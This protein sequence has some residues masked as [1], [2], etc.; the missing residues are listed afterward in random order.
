MH[1]RN[2]YIARFRSDIKTQTLP[3]IWGVHEGP[4]EEYQLLDEN[5]QHERQS[6]L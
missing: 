5:P 2:L 6:H 3:V 1:L 4:T